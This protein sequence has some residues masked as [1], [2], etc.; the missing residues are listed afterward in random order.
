MKAACSPRMTLEAI[1]EIQSRAPQVMMTL[2]PDSDHHIT[3]DNPA[4][5]IRAAREFLTGVHITRRQDHGT[6]QTY[7]DSNAG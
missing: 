2:V 1:A 5:F 4:G 3:L 6:D 7:R